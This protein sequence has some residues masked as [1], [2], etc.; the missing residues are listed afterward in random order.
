MNSSKYL[1]MFLKNKK[2]KKVCQNGKFDIAVLRSQGV[3]VENFYFDTMLASY[4][5]DPD[6]KHG[7]DDLSTKI[8]KF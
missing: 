3:N 7:M 8:F 1:S 6:Q 5:I 2:I 4:I